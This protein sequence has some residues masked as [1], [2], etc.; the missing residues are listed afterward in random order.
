MHNIL[1]LDTEVVI[2]IVLILSKKVNG[3]NHYLNNMRQAQPV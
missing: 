1:N 3:L 2:C